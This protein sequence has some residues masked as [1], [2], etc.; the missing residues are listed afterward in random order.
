MRHYTDEKIERLVKQVTPLGLWEYC[1]HKNYF[2]D[3][4]YIDKNYL[5]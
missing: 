4:N 2:E 3:M 5:K 1:K